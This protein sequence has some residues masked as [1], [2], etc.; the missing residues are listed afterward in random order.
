[1]EIDA[2]RSGIGVVLTH[3]NKPIAFFSQGLYD[4]N[5][6]LSVYEREMLAL[7]TVVQ[8]WRPYLLGRKFTIK[9]DYHSLKYL[10]EQKITI[11]SQQ[12]WLVKL[13]GYDYTISY[14][15]GKY[16]IVIDALSRKQEPIQL[17]SIS[18]VQSQLL[19]VVKD[20]WNQDVKL[21]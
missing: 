18:S 14:K 8:K 13:L 3:H 19:E 4:R 17:F 12:K 11:L 7:V 16:N 15:K 1:M 6:A 9:T 5:K 21:Q 20:S 2:S 10:L